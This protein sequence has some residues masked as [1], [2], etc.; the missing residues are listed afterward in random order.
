MR[1]GGW[2]AQRV[3]RPLKR[4]ADPL[5][6]H[7]D[8]PSRVVLATDQVTFEGPEHVAAEAGPQVR[9]RVEEADAVDAPRPRVRDVDRRRRQRRRRF[10]AVEGVDETE[11][12]SGAD[13]VQFVERVVVPLV[14]GDEQ[15]AVAVERQPRREAV[16]RGDRFQRERPR[17]VGRRRPRHESQDVAVVSRRDGR[18]PVEVWLDSP[19]DKNVVVNDSNMASSISSAR[20]SSP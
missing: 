9:R 13:V 7:A 11:V 6:R 14:V 18:P 4:L 17:V 16:P 3:G 15:F 19:P 20:K 10:A 12:S 8:E 1:I 5:Q 2:D